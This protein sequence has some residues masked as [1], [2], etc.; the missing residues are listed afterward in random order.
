[1]TDPQTQFDLISCSGHLLSS[2]PGTSMLDLLI[3]NSNITPA[4]RI[5]EQAGIS[6]KA[7]TELRKLS[8]PEIGNIIMICIPKNRLDEV[9]YRSH[10]YGV[11]CRCFNEN[12]SKEKLEKLQSGSLDSTSC[13]DGN[14]AQFRIVYPSLDT[15]KGDRIFRVTPIDKDLKKKRNQQIRQ[16]LR[17]HL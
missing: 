4:L 10:S 14:N 8:Y 3:A 12:D 1:M 9:C 7:T 17:S 6:A 16:I 5:Y 11:P 15:S 2:D 13:I